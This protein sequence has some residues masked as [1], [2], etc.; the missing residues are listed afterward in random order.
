MSK[1]KRSPL[2]REHPRRL[3]VPLLIAASAITLVVGLFMP[4]VR[5]ESTLA[6]DS[7]YS[8]MGGIV[9][10]FGDGKVVIGSIILL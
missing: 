6:A 1:P 10:Y 5:I 8:I 2:W 4:I 9:G 3:D 7:S